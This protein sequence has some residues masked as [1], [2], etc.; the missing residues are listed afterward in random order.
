MPIIALPMVQRIYNTMSQ[1]KE[2][3]TPLDPNRVRL[4]LCGVTPYAPSHI[5]HARGLVAFDVVYRWLLRQYPKVIYVR[6]FTD[7]D[8]KIIKAANEEGIEAVALAARYIELYHDSA[9]K[10]GCLPPTHEPKV[11]ETIPEIVALIERIITNGKAYP[12]AGDVYFEVKQF[13]A[14]GRLSGRTLLDLEQ[15]EAGARV[16]VDT[17]K[18]S[19]FDFALWKAAKPGE[20]AWDSPW[21]RG[22][23]GWHIE[24]S[25]M[26]SKFLGETFDIHGGGKD[27]VFPHHENEIAQ[28]CAAS[29]H[30]VYAHIWMHNGFV[31]LMPEGC[32]KCEHTLP[33]GEGIPEK[34]SACGYVYAED[35]FKMS[36]SRG[37]FY[38]MHELIAEYEPEALRTLLLSSHYRT[39]IRF[40]HALVV[41]TERRVG[42]SYAALSA[43]DSFVRQN[44]SEDGPS[45]ESAFGSNPTAIFEE[46]M[47]DDFNTARAIAEV[48][49]LFTL[50]NEL[51]AAREQER[52]G[53][54]L[55]AKERSWLLGQIR[56]FIRSQGEVLGVYLE[57][58]EA[59][60]LRRKQKFLAAHGL[61]A[62]D[63]E[64]KIEA[65]AEARRNKDFAKGDALRDELAALGLSL[66][67][68]REGTSWDVRDD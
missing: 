59:Y 41:D 16:E 33:D 64:A 61:S 2:V 53:K 27:L 48:Q 43:M 30:E 32:P 54:K 23:P 62:A 19:P 60:L 39:P 63:I 1:K 4:Y 17:R 29:G 51:L 34:C 55:K 45:F 6:N 37:N 28:S 31:N 9:A 14:Y 8:D 57:A 36:K 5:G 35:D 11:S 58:P 10:L 38:P 56:G 65:R 68:A 25:A 49:E 20:P 18:R 13:P 52:L 21:G 44:P 66:Q 42:R 7:I 15:L 12:V 3:F 22:R 40:S 46:A 67:D 24:C 47:E 50:G 26:S